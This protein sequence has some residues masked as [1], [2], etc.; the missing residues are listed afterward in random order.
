MDP[1]LG[2]GG[3]EGIPEELPEEEDPVIPEV[4]SSNINK[5][6]ETTTTAPSSALGGERANSK[7][8]K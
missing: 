2:G 5:D 6:S 4:V 1:T 3:D 7:P 8:S